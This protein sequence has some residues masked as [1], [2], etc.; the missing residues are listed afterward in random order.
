M[1]TTKHF[2]IKNNECLLFKIQ[3]ETLKGKYIRKNTMSIIINLRSEKF[4]IN[5]LQLGN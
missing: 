5:L 4:C 1:T 2:C 3:G